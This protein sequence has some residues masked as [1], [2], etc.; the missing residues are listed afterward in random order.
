M[1]AESLAL[2]MKTKQL[3][4]NIIYLERTGSTNEDAKRIVGE[5]APSGTLV[6]TDCQ[7]MGKGRRGRS[8]ESPAGMN[9]YFTLMLKPDFV[10]NKASMLTLVMA[11][12]V[13]KAIEEETGV[14]PGIKW[15]NDIV[16]EGR[17]V[18]GILTEMLLEAGR[19]QAVV[20]GCGINVAQTAFSAELSEHASSLLLSCKK[21]VSREQLLARIMEQF[22]KYYDVF[23]KTLNLS[24]MQAEYEG[25]LVNKNKQV[26]VLDPVDEYE[27]RALG[28]NEEGEL[29]VELADGSISKVYAGEVSVRGLY[30]YV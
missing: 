18:C 14:H 26:R 5:G 17:K 19:I 11:L 15:P 20:I 1:N 6:V 4:R 12:S 21:S 10:P 3:G 27:G 2:E 25:Y 23:C 13:A 22:E 16:I 8:W 9:L 29:L 7:E 30:G 24:A 28:I